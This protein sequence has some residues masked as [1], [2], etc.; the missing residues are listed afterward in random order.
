MIEY[1]GNCVINFNG[2]AFTGTALYKPE[3]SDNAVPALVLLNINI[4]DEFKEFAAKK[5]N[6]NVSDIDVSCA[7]SPEGEAV[8]AMLAS[9]GD[10]GGGDS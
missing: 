1:L 8:I 4:L 9:G 7:M 10:G 3:D 6:C 5:L 2:A